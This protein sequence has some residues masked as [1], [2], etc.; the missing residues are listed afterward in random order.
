MGENTRVAKTRNFAIAVVFLFIVIFSFG[1]ISHNQSAHRASE[2]NNAKRIVEETNALQ[3]L[4]KSC[5]S[6]DSEQAVLISGDP[7][8]AQRI[9]SVNKMLDAIVQARCISSDTLSVIYSNPFFGLTKN[10]F[11]ALASGTPA[12]V[13]WNEA[14]MD[15]DYGLPY[16]SSGGSICE[17]GTQSSSRGSGTCAD[18]GGYA[19]PRGHKW[20]VS[21]WNVI[22]GPNNN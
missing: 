11:N 17:D 19:Q 10:S 14:L 20:D 13:L 18:H 7:R 16:L 2:A 3:D 4:G 1:V 12:D 21:V 5:W 9:N 22:S 6:L 8:S 15:V